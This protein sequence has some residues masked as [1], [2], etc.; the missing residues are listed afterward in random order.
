VT[1]AQESARWI[2]ATGNR[3]KVE[4]FRTLLAATGIELI[5]QTALGIDSVDETGETFVEN[6]LLKARH[7][8]RVSGL[9]A[10]ADDSGLVVDALGGAPGIHSARYAG[11]AADDRANILKLLDA[12]R[13]VPEPRRGACFYCVIVALRDPTDPT[14]LIA[15]GR[16]RGAIA[17]TAAGAGGFGYDPVFFDPRLRATAAQLTPDAKHRVSHRGQALRAIVEQLLAGSVA[18]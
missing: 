10:I 4:E 9:P 17:A 8:S 3:G 7:A 6:A 11:P 16:W 5:P 12:L 18:G 13:G 2:L 1:A 15:I 14:P